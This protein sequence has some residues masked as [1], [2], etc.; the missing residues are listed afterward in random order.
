MGSLGWTA[1]PTT[2]IIKN[3]EKKCK[4]TVKNSEI[5]RNFCD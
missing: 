1:V 2:L 3:C 5:I 4:K